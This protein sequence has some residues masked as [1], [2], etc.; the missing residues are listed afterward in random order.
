MGRANCRRSFFV[1]SI[2]VLEEKFFKIPLNEI[3][4]LTK[5]RGRKSY[6]VRN[7]VDISLWG[8]RHLAHS[9]GPDHP[10]RGISEAEI[11]RC[12]SYKQTDFGFSP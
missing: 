9:Q 8:A 11:D 10:P 6:K 2:N 4:L 3:S 12:L 7:F 1:F 5:I